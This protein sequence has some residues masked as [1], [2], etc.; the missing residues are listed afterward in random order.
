MRVT[1]LSATGAIGG[2]ERVLLDC[3]RATSASAVSLVA[4]GDGPLLAEAARLGADTRVV[5]APGALGAAGDAFGAGG[6]LH[7]ALPILRA[8]PGFMNR[9]SQV[10]TGFAPDIVHS[11]GLKTHVLS[12][13][14]PRRAKVVW[15]VHDYIGTR[16]VSSRILRLLGHRCDV[17]IAVSDSIAADARTVLPDAVPV[18]TVHNAVDTVRFAPEGARLDLDG[19]SGLP[20]AA[21]DTI[22]IGLPATFAKWKGHDVFLEAIARL[23]RADVRAYI[24]GGPL[25]QTQNSQWTDEELRQI[26]SRLQIDGRVGFTGIVDDMPAAY[27]ALDVVV[28]ASTRPEPFGLVIAEAMACGSALVA[29]PAGGAGELFVDSVHAIGAAGG[30]AGALASAL[31]RLVSDTDARVAMRR[32]AREHAVRQFGHGRFSSALAQVLGRFSAATASLQ[33]V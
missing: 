33:A 28:H 30:D 23:R 29:A 18:V 19:L 14:L 4:L 3:I 17:A 6:V 9:F 26:A 20:P 22:R 32:A 10:V 27:R 24:I 2:A 8:F 13:M 25:Y 7:D 1:C 16:A 21:P 12:A 11:H 15:H 31:D 5:N